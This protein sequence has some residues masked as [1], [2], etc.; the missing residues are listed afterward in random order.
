MKGC[1]RGLAI[2]YSNHSF[3]RCQLA[4][5]RQII[6]MQPLI[7][8]CD[9]YQYN[10]PPK[11]NKILCQYRLMGLEGLHR[12]LTY[13]REV[14]LDKDDLFLYDIS[15]RINTVHGRVLQS[16][17]KKY[18]F[19]SPLRHKKRKKVQSNCN[20]KRTGILYFY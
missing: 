14:A 1:Q 5:Y 2:H 12:N 17:S 13:N 9:W 18:K 3:P 16:L 15:Q 11:R 4:H 6:P 7:V 20:K 8:F 19:K 10:H